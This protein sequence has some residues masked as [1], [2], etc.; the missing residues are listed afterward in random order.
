MGEFV[1]V[2]RDALLSC[3]LGIPNYSSIEEKGT[4]SCENSVDNLEKNLALVRLDPGKASEGRIIQR[5]HQLFER[6]V[7]QW[8]VEGVTLGEISGG[9]VHACD[10]V[11]FELFSELSRWAS[12]NGVRGRV[13]M[14]AYNCAINN[15]KWPEAVDLSEL[16]PLFTS[17]DNL[18]AHRI[19]DCVELMGWPGLSLG[20]YVPIDGLAECEM[21]RIS[22]LN[23]NSIS[24]GAATRLLRLVE[25][26][27]DDMVCDDRATEGPI[28]IVSISEYCKRVRKILMKNRF[29]HSSS[30][31]LLAPRRTAE[32]SDESDCEGETCRIFV[33][34][35]F[36][37]F[38]IEATRDFRDVVTIR[39]AKDVC[40]L[41]RI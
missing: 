7:Y 22:F 30:D 19:A 14:Q 17:R 32:E 35:F 11:S 34:S 3:I 23:L 37:N 10:A 13:T 20:P 16:S 12:Y 31:L 9:E 27:F 26:K 6:V 21:S 4:Q 40:T 28:L 38:E 33:L 29:Y 1:R 24:E 36:D 25:S 8:Y 2:W 5:F 15:A 39:H 41:F 18:P